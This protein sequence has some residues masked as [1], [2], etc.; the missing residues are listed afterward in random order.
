M[1]E[2]L[3]YVG[4]SFFCLSFGLEGHRRMPDAEPVKESKARRVLGSNVEHG[5]AVRVVARDL[6]HWRERIQAGLLTPRIDIRDL[7]N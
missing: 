4:F 3:V 7:P 2:I 1:P 6:E 5:F